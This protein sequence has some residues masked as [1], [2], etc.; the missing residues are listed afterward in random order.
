MT[1]NTKNIIEEIEIPNDVELTINGPLISVKGQ[2]GGLERRFSHPKIKI[3]KKDNKLIL[4]SI[5]KPS[6]KEKTIINTFKAHIKNMIIGVNK[7]Y[8]NKLKICSSHFPVSVSIEGSELIIKNF[9]G[10]KIPRRAKIVPNSKIEI[11][12]E[13]ITITSIDKEL[14]GQTASNIEI[15]TKIRGRDRRVFGDGIFLTNKAGKPIK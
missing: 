4:E 8:T 2:N 1:K 3:F 9:L 15:A 6:K 12:G 7:F 5:K 13:D 10:E 14:A 11:K